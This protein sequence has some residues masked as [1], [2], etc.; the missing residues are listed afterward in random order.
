MFERDT[1]ICQAESGHR[2]ELIA[3]QFVTSKAKTKTHILT[4]LPRAAAG[5]H[6]LAGVFTVVHNGTNGDAHNCEGR[7]IFGYVRIRIG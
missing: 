4:V 1:V 2:F 5:T 6:N 3:Y 7:C